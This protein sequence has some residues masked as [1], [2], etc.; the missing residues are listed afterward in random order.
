MGELVR[1][2]AWLLEGGHLARVSGEA[3]AP[4]MPETAV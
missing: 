3:Q 4:G 2:G 1:C